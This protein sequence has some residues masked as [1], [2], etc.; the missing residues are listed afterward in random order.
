M[1][2]T[3]TR[4][5]ALEFEHVS[6][7]FGGLLALYDVSFKVGENEI[8]GLIGPN[9]AGKTTAFNVACG[10]QKPTSG[11]IRFPL[12]GRGSLKPPQLARSGIARTLQGVGLFSH[13][14][15]M[16]N[17]MA[18]AQ[19]RLGGGTW[20]SVLGLPSGHRHERALREEAM[21]QLQRLGITKFASALP[22]GIP[23]GIAK[24]VSIAR[25]L[26]QSPSL[27]MLDEPASGLDE[28]ELEDFIA[29]IVE[30]RSS[31]SVL[32]VEHNMDFVMQLV[33]QLVVLNFGQVIAKGS[34]SEINNNPDVLAA[35]LGIDE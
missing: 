21:V 13:M 14:S 4:Q 29:L 28:N 5:F 32:L 1:T 15:V 9:G 33:Q 2:E 10:F 11:T 16:E 27:L 3:G 20:S 23:Y 26:M 18:G 7:R 31:M 22:S 30:L 19:S 35:Y 8:V 12:L 6:V 17:V 25:A 24:K 34:P